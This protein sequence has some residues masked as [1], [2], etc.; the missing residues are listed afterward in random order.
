MSS[1]GR[2][3]RHDKGLVLSLVTRHFSL[4]PDGAAVD[5]GHH[6]RIV[7]WRFIPARTALSTLRRIFFT[8]ADS[9]FTADGQGSADHDRGNRTR[10]SARA[11]RGR[12]AFAG[13]SR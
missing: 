8:L 11:A 13:H 12:F 7:A 10:K 9:A 4:L 2:G 1:R 3:T 5:L 6:C